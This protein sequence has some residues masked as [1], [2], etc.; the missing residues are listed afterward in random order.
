MTSFE[1]VTICMGTEKADELE[2]DLYNDNAEIIVSWF[3]KPTG[4]ICEIGG[5]GTL[6]WKIADDTFL[7]IAYRNSSS[8]DEQEDELIEWSQSQDDLN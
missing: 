5:V 2:N 1:V 3:H 6:K 8:T 4:E 7:S